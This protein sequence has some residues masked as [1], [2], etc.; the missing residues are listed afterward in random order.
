M[1]NLIL[2]ADLENLGRFT[3]FVTAYAEENGFK[4]AQTD[5]IALCLEEAVVNIC[6]YAYPDNPDGKI[7]I[8]LDMEKGDILVIQIKDSGI[9]FDILSQKDPDIN[10]GVS[11]REIGGLGIFFIK[12]MMDEVKYDRTENQNILTMILKRET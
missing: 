1:S 11:D 2:Q 4:R 9:P 3:E 6:S 10:A 8:S 7:E 12:K 5:R